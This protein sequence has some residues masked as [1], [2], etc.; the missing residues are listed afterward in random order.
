MEEKRNI[1]IQLVKAKMP[2]TFRGVCKDKGEGSYLIILNQDKSEEEQA[3]S[4]LHEMLHI[5][6]ND[7]DSCLDLD[8]LEKI[9]HGDRALKPL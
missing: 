8:E 9:R 6:Y 2:E 5:Y 1:Q 7:F 4:F 3:Q